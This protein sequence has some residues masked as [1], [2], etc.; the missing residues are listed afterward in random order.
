MKRKVAIIAAFLLGMSLPLFAQ[1]PMAP[2]FLQLPFHH[3]P[4]LYSAAEDLSV[5]RG[6]SEDGTANNKLYFRVGWGDC[7]AVFVDEWDELIAA[8]PQDRYINMREYAV[9]RLNPDDQ[10]A[11]GADEEYNC[12]DEPDPSVPITEYVFEG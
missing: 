12:P 11:W 6:T 9:G 5:K 10:G 1:S 7:L 3:W 4:A 2:K 8:T